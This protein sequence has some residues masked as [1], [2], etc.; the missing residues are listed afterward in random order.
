MNQFIFTFQQSRLQQIIE[1]RKSLIYQTL[2]EFNSEL[3]VIRKVCRN[4]LQLLSKYIITQQ[5]EV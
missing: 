1:I 2:S 5:L 4:I 3:Q